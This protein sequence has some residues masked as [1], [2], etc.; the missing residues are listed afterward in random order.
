VTTHIKR[1]HL[2]TSASKVL[3]PA[4]FVTIFVVVSFLLV[5]ALPNNQSAASNSSHYLFLPYVTRNAFTRPIWQPS[6]GTS[7]QIQFTGQIDTSL[8]VQVFDLD[9]V[10]TPKSIIDQ[11]HTKGAKVVCYFSAGT[12]EPWRSDADDFPDSVLG[13]DLEGWPDEK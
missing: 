1:L 6:P 2:H 11:L 9:M 13:D 8:D 4:P 10:D 5:V 7:W 12:W 3:L